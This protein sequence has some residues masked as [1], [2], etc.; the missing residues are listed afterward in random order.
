MASFAV[1]AT[2]PQRIHSCASTSHK[3]FVFINLSTSLECGDVFCFPCIT[4][5]VNEIQ[6]RT[7]QQS[8]PRPIPPDLLQALRKPLADLCKYFEAVRYRKE[9]AGPEYICPKC[10]R[11]LK[12]RPVRVFDRNTLEQV[13]M[14]P[15]QCDTDPESNDGLLF[16]DCSLL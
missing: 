11:L 7:N 14:T 4:G 5:Y 8:D 3:P 13:F 15:G 12:H 1:F 9:H 10:G 6:T 2:G 16:V